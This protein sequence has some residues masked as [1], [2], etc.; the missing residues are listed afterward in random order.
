M[1][2]VFDSLSSIV[3]SLLNESL[4]NRVNAI[5][6]YHSRFAHNLGKSWEYFWVK[7]SCENSYIEA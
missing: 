2:R 3:E 5:D 6:P 4:A 7:S 1:V